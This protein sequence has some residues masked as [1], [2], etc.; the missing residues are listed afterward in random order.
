MNILA[1][2]LPNY[3]DDLTFAQSKISGLL[4]RYSSNINFTNNSKKIKKIIE[5]FNT[6]WDKN[7]KATLS[8]DTHSIDY[9]WGKIMIIFTK[10]N[11]VAIYTNLKSIGINV[12]NVVLDFMIMATLK[13]YEPDSKFR[14][15]DMLKWK[16]D[17]QV[18]L[19]NLLECPYLDWLLDFSQ[20]EED[21]ETAIKLDEWYRSLGKKIVFYGFSKN[22]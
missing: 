13:D 16:N 17:A 4:P 18:A 8:I 6:C 15:C 2:I 10:F 19:Y 5:F 3:L 1:H 22:F 20:S 14:E 7:T 9:K 21:Y 12:L 11:Q